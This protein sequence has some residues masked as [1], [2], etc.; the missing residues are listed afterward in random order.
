[1]A[2]I[3]RSLDSLNKEVE[4]K[5]DKTTTYTKTEVDA[6]I[7]AAT[8]TIPVA[9]ATQEGVAKMGFNAVSGLLH[10]RTDGGDIL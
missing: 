6:A 10:I 7:G 9:S 5:A 3:V 1:M 8:P 4:L 2:T